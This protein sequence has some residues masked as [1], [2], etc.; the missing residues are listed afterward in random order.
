M[1]VQL[2]ISKKNRLIIF[3][4]I[5]IFAV[6]LK[7]NSVYAAFDQSDANRGETIQL[8]DW[9]YGV[10]PSGNYWEGCNA[11]G[12]VYL[13]TT[14]SN[15]NSKYKVSGI[16]D[17]SDIMQLE[18]YYKNVKAGEWQYIDKV[19][20]NSGFEYGTAFGLDKDSQYAILINRNIGGPYDGESYSVRVDEIRAPSIR[21]I[22]PTV[23]LSAKSY[24]YDG[25][26]KTPGITVKDGNT[27]LKKN[28]DYSVSYA[29]GR[30]N[31]GTYKV[32]VALKGN[33]SGSNAVT[34]RINKAANNLSIKAK[35]TAV[36][37]T[38][39]KKKVQTLAVSK[40]INFKKKGQGAKTYSKASGNKMIT[41][42]KKTG[43]VTIKKGLKKGTYKV[44]VKVRAAGNTNYKA[45]T[46]TVTFKIKVK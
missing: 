44:K 8:N 22:T 17:G 38:K 12:P 18:V 15:S 26:I 31:A 33:Y 9:V 41:I 1:N 46:K 25:T 30:K 43:K 24:T 39:V 16:N 13:F 28:T 4:M 3:I 11:I 40:V 23:V 35:N 34:F 20:V 45:V 36:K 6:L 37:Y 29:A 42:N 27:V 5:S 14:S 7:P 2:L 32:T 10:M 21:T 19:S